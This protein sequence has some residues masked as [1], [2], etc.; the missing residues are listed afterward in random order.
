MFSVT[1]SVLSILVGIANATGLITNLDQPVLD[2]FSDYTFTNV[3][4]DKQALTIRHLLK[5][6][7][8]IEW[9]QGIVS[10]YTDWVDIHDYDL[11][12]NTTND[13]TNWPMSWPYNTENDW[14]Q[15]ALSDDCVKFVLDRPMEYSPGTHFW[16][17]NG[18]SHLLSAIIQ[19][20]TGM[21]AEAYAKEYLFNPL[22][23]TEYVW[24]ND[25]MGI[26]MGGTGLWLRPV[27]MVKIG[28]LY[29]NNGLWDTTQIVPEEWIVDSTQEYLPNTY[30]GYQWWIDKEN[31]YYTAV[32]LGGQHI[33]VKPDVNL[34]ISI[35]S[36]NYHTPAISYTS[37]VLIDSFIIKSITDTTTTET[38]TTTT[39]STT[40]ES[41]SLNLVFILIGMG[42][43][44]FSKKERNKRNQ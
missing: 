37:K 2:I 9:N 27:D 28:Y 35:T 29:L 39:D 33:V 31:N 5:M 10:G 18:D 38:P 23:I 15:M 26:S 14:Y 16:Y 43:F 3:D 13:V 19:N 30:Y 22:N 17:S 4:A 41:T 1:K 6:Q 7:S 34:V 40:T 8:G 36:S 24:W 12:T 25:S 21:N 11:F 44:I 42:V 20:K 32:G